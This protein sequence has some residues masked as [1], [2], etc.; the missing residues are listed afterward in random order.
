MDMVYYNFIFQT[1]S[2]RFPSKSGSEK[3]ALR[4]VTL[5]HPLWIAQPSE[6]TGKESREGDIKPDMSGAHLKTSSGAVSVVEAESGG[7]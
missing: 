1:L 5:T 4:G 2:S 3:L 6:P 7:N